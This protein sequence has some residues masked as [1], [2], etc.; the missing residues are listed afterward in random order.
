MDRLEKVRPEEVTPKEL[1][2]VQCLGFR[3]AAY[4]DDQ[5]KWREFCRDVL[6]PDNARIVEPAM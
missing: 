5:G 2:I 1:V 6:L 4:R 3:C